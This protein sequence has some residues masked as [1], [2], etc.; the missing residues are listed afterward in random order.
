MNECNQI[1]AIN[2]VRSGDN[3]EMEAILKRIQSRY[4][5]HGYESVELFYTDNCC[6]EYL[7]LLR[8]MPSL[9]HGD[10]SAVVGAA[11]GQ[12]ELLLLPATY[13][14]CVMDSYASLVAFCDTIIAIAD[15]M[16]ENG[17]GNGDG[18]GDGDGDSD[19]NGDGNLLLGVDMEWD[20]LTAEERKQ[21]KPEIL[22]MATADGKNIAVFKL[23]KVFSGITKD[24]T[25]ET[26]SKFNILRKLF[27]HPRIQAS[28]VNV[29]GDITRFL[30]YYPEELIGPT[31]YR[32][33]FDATNVGRKHYVV[34]HGRHT[35][36]LEDLVSTLLGKRI[37]KSLARSK[38]SADVQRKECVQYAALD[39]LASAMVS[40]EVARLVRVDRKPM[41]EELNEGVPV[42]L[43]PLRSNEPAA[44][45]RVESKEEEEELVP[46]SGSRKRR[47]RKYVDVR[48][49]IIKIARPAAFVPHPLPE[50]NAGNRSLRDFSEGDTVP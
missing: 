9:G 40:K 29:R 18:C 3:S 47:V 14:P 20:S 42:R 11:R 10:A 5:I 8:A 28:G 17:D 16:D 39:A 46:T 19:G 32:R 45:A 25:Q 4:D 2:F 27:D 37:M 30:Q 35:G 34:P 15:G 6:H 13:K 44:Y 38:W 36:R 50:M 48:V 43:L 22:Q 23:S 12:L 31:T 41:L 7:M 1:V 33:A 24:S 49:K 21:Q 26:V